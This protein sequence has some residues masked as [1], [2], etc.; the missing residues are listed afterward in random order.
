[1]AK[2]STIN[3]RVNSE[4]K[5]QAGMI[6]DAM[7]LSFSDAFNLMLH[8]IKI[9]RSLPF[10]VVRTATHQER[11]PFHIWNAL[12]TAKKNLSARFPQKR[13]YGSLWTYE[14]YTLYFFL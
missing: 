8:Q 5:E 14:V 12:K 11:K 10:E 6:L 1:M 2:N 4:V 9:Q 13:N 3:L 7:G